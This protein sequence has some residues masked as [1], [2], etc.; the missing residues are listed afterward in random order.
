MN[1][2]TEAFYTGSTVEEESSLNDIDLSDVDLNN[3]YEAS[4]AEA[5]GN[6]QSTYDQGYDEGF[7]KGWEA[8][9]SD[10][11]DGNDQNDDYDDGYHSGFTAGAEAEQARIQSVLRTMMEASMNL[12]QGNKAV[13]YKHAMEILRPM[14]IDYSEEAYK[15]SMEEDGF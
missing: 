14:N 10:I 12:G 3:E 9:R 6:T 1:E 13:Q 11:D 5:F 2:N 4:V 15:K 8:A 7:D